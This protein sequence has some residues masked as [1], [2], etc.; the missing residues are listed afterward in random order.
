M[1]NVRPVVLATLPA[2]TKSDGAVR[3]TGHMTCV[4]VPGASRPSA[5]FTSNSTA[6]VRVVTSTA[7]E[8]RDTEPVNVWP[9]YAATENDKGSA[10]PDQILATVMRD[11]GRVV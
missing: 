5:L 6:I 4:N 1:T 9:G 11:G 2:G 3:R 10:T 8:I 7:C